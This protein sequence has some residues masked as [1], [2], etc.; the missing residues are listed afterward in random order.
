MVYARQ[1]CVVGNSAEAGKCFLECKL[2]S[3]SFFLS[4]F[5]LLFFFFFA[6][7]LWQN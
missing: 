2:A 4:F 3:F 7:E 5:F 6:A 1:T